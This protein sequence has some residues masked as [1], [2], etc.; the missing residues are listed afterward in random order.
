VIVVTALLAACA[1]SI[2]P[3][4][5]A[6][7]AS[8]IARIGS[9]TPARF[10]YAPTEF[11][12][13]A[14][15]AS[16]IARGH[17]RTLDA[18][19]YEFEV[20]HWIAGANSR[21]TLR[22]QRFQDWT[23]A[24]RYEPYAVGQSFVLFAA[25][26]EV[27]PGE[28]EWCALGAACEGEQQLDAAGVH[29]RGIPLEGS[30]HDPI[31]LVEFE[32]AVLGLRECVRSV[33][34]AGS[35][36]SGY[37][38]VENAQRLADYAESSDLAA[39]VIARL[40]RLDEWIEP[41]G[42][43]ESDY[44]PDPYTLRPSDVP[45]WTWPFPRGT[46]AFRQPCTFGR[47][48]ALTRNARGDIELW[49]SET[50]RASRGQP[51]GGLLC[52]TFGAAGAGP[53]WSARLGPSTLPCTL[54]TDAPPGYGSLLCPLGDCGF[55]GTSA[56]LIGNGA[57]FG[58][59]GS[60]WAYVEASPA[61]SLGTHEVSNVERLDELWP[62]PTR[63]LD[64]ASLSGTDIVLLRTSPTPPSPLAYAALDLRLNL[65]RLELFG[66]EAC[67]ANDVQATGVAGLGDLDG[68]GYGDF[69]LALPHASPPGAPYSSRGAI[70]IVLRGIRTTV[71]GTHTIGD[72][73][74]DLSIPLRD[75]EKFGSQLASP[76]DVDGDGI[77]DL[78]ATS[79][80]GLWVLFLARDG[81]VRDFRVLRTA[82]QERRWFGV[83]SLAALAAQTPQARPRVAWTRLDSPGEPAGHTI[84]L[85]A[86]APDGNAIRW[87][88]A[89]S[90]GH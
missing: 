65:A 77:Q 62:E 22:V 37:A 16:A 72:D 50:Q 87:A 9:L 5:L 48:L 34:A 63:E 74:G 47:E 83:E 69:A 85:F 14:L 6:S 59:K 78:L 54:G 2:V 73:S 28:F 68:N 1:G 33:S 61:L 71:V 32:A 55:E 27:A 41:A 25:Q 20:E 49:T 11:V 51:R 86:L 4:E 43:H 46:L 35:P 66:A 53:R 17:I 89:A 30:R 26:A 58:H 64:A 57:D 40:R 24:S 60:L 7:D 42:A 36:R 90:A 84:E 8:L 39:S 79:K 3:P 45:A 82:P 19:R 13:L 88:D 67:T 44:P 70:R 76:G 15:H 80:R 12:A 75:D 18:T 10:D 23:C 29:L 52:A 38:P 56:L 31:P 81:S 21:S